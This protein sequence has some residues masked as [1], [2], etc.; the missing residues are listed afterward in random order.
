MVSKLFLSPILIRYSRNIST[1]CMHCECLWFLACTCVF[2]LFPGDSPLL[3]KKKEPPPS[4][5]GKVLPEKQ[6]IYLPWPPKA[7]QGSIRSQL[8]LSLS[9][10]HAQALTM[11][12]VT[13]VNVSSK[14][15]SQF[16]L[17]MMLLYSIIWYKTSLVLAPTQLIQTTVACPSCFD[18]CCMCS[19][20][21]KKKAFQPQNTFSAS[22]QIHES[23]SPQ[24][25]EY[26]RPYDIYCHRN[27][28]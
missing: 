27:S 9:P 10:I 19:V 17:V 4:K 15:N 26:I 13:A 11:S 6:W 8:Q 20:L 7:F 1:T 23:A 21:A 12:I 2:L 22:L 28:T 25:A 18:N 5:V 14:T 3:T 24:S 16:C